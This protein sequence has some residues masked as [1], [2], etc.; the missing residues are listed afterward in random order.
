MG[1]PDACG[2]GR[3][4]VV[5][6]VAALATRRST[7]AIAEVRVA[8]VEGR[9]GVP[10]SLTH[11]VAFLRETFDDPSTRFASGAKN[12]KE[13]VVHELVFLCWF[14][15]GLSNELW[16]CQRV[17]TGSISVAAG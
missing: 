5:G 16:P 6:E 2:G 12:E 3:S 14:V 11:C 10:R 8:T 15:V 7:N 1:L 13:G 9:I 4:S 17:R